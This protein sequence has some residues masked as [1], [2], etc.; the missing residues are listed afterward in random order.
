[1]KKKKKKKRKGLDGPPRDKMVGS[2]RD[3]LKVVKK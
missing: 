1:M 2:N 3:I